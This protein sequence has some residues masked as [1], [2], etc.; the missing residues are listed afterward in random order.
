MAR[1]RTFIMARG[2]W[3]PVG[4]PERNMQAAVR[5]QEHLVHFGFETDLRS[6]RWWGRWV[7]V[8]RSSPDSVTTEG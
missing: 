6:R 4:D 3:W 1:Y 5:W 2:Q 8:R 7:S